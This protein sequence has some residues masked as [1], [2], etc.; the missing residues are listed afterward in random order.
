MYGHLS[1]LKCVLH[2]KRNLLKKYLQIRQEITKKSHEVTCNQTLILNIIYSKIYIFEINIEVPVFFNH[3]FV[4]SSFFVQTWFER[5][6]F[7][8]TGIGDI[9]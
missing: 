8:L 3:L 4:Y 7:Q 9:V 6:V 1:Q 5:K 2:L